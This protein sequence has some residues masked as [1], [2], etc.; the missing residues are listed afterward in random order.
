MSTLPPPAT[1][2]FPDSS[3][4]KKCYDIADK[5]KEFIPIANDRNRLGFNLVKF[6]QGEGD[7][8]EILVKSAK[9]KLEGISPK[10]LAAKIEEEL[11]K[12]N[13]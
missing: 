12:M 8:P 6:V 5:F 4:E 13:K 2:K 1:N 7:A 10:D 11:I 3:I 9:L